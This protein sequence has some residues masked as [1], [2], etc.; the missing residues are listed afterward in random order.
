MNLRQS[1]ARSFGVGIATIAVWGLA[2]LVYV[3]ILCPPHRAWERVRNDQSPIVLDN[4][5]GVARPGDAIFVCDTPHAIGPFEWHRDLGCYC[6]PSDIPVDT[7]AAS[8]G[9]TC[10]I[11]KP[12]PGRD[13]DWGACRFARCSHHADF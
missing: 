5:E 3:V 1:L 11:D 4:G 8:V 9:G 12:R 10:T 6:A 13:D 7:L 2:Q